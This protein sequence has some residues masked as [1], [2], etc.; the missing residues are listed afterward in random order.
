MPHNADIDKRVQD[1]KRFHRGGTAETWIE[2]EA[3]AKHV[4]SLLIEARI[5]E[6]EQFPSLTL[7]QCVLRDKRIAQLRQQKKQ[8]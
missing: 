4:N 2:W 3:L 5:S 1:L 7:H 6:L 8:L